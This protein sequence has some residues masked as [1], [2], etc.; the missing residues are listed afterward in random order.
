[1]GS[2][3]HREN[4]FADGGTIGGGPGASGS[5]SCLVGGGVLVSIGLVE[6]CCDCI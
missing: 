1:M 6:A 5:G 4:L 3:D 2:G